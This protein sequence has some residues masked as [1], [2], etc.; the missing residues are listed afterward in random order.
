[1]SNKTKEIKDK[2]IWDT[3]VIAQKEHTFLHAWAWGSLNKVMG[4]K[5][6]RLGLYEHEKLIAVALIIKVHAK[7][8][9]FLFMPHGPI[10]TESENRYEILKNFIEKFKQIAKSEKV[11]FIR[12][13]P[14]LLDTEKNKEYFKKLDF[15]PAPIYMHAETTWALDIGPPEHPVS[16]YDLMMGMRKNTRNLIRRAEKEGVKIISGTSTEFI[17]EFLTL[18]KKT[19]QK[20]GFV[21]FSD[22][23]IQE[24]IK[25]F[26]GD[27]KIYLAQWHNKIISAAIIVFYG[28]SAFYHHGANSNE[29]NKIPAAYLL[30]WQIIKDAK[31][32]GKTYYNFWGISKDEAN[33][34]HP[35]YGLSF[36]KKGFGGYR[37]DYMHAQDLPLNYGYWINYIIEKIRIWKRGI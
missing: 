1:M 5:V 17:H 20:H 2:N 34:K 6:F 9:N 11:N 36:F 31:N 19:A 15:R 30:Q 18:Y 4:D 22:K 23:F 25:K 32:E 21:A 29:Y 3:F 12:V 8:G 37:T 24:E 28:N 14:L 16:D 7:R 13:S 33:K 26:N 27:A 35:W 10:F